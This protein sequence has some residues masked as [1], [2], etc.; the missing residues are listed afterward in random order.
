MYLTR[1]S[2][3]TLNLRIVKTCWKKNPYLGLHSFLWLNSCSPALSPQ[4]THPTWSPAC[5]PLIHSSPTGLPVGKHSVFAISGC[6]HS[7]LPC[8]EHS[9]PRSVSSVFK[10]PVGPWRGLPHHTSWNYPRPTH[11][12]PGHLLYCSPVL[13]SSWHCTPS[14]QDLQLLHICIHV[15]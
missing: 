14:P 7:P 3:L 9:T 13:F 12:T 8:L 2:V 11:P 15:Y 1:F 5:L 4:N 10:L 6:L